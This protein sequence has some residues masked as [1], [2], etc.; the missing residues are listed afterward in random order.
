[1]IPLPSVRTDHE[2]STE[3][4]ND[5]AK[6]AAELCGAGENTLEET[7]WFFEFQEKVEQRRQTGI[8]S[9]NGLHYT[10]SKNMETGISK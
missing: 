2:E 5:I 4:W 9:I 10:S 1:M 3:V 8:S 7:R 6:L